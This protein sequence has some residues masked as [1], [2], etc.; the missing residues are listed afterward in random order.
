VPRRFPILG[1][2]AKRAPAAQALLHLPLLMQ[3]DKNMTFEKIS[4]H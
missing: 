1:A 3:R 2:G 4:V